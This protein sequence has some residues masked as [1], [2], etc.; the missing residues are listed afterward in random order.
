MTVIR[1]NSG[2]STE[3][4]LNRY[5]KR[6]DSWWSKEDGKQFEGVFGCVNQINTNQSHR[7]LKN[8]IAMQM[9]TNSNYHSKGMFSTN[10][11]SGAST[12]RRKKQGK[13]SLNVV[14]SATDTIV[15]KLGKNKVKPM[16]LTYGGDWFM[17]EK[18]KELGKFLQGAFYDGDFYSQAPKALLNACIFGT[19]FVKVTSPNRKI[20]YENVF[21][22]EIKVDEMDGYYGTPRN[23]YQERFIDKSTLSALYPEHADKI[24]A[25]AVVKDVVSGGTTELLRVVEA[26]HLPA[27]SESKDGK[28]AI[29]IENCDL[30]N[31]PWERESFPFAIFRWSELPVGFFGASVVD[32]LKEIQAEMNALLQSAQE[33][34]RLCSKPKVIVW[35]NSEVTTDHLNNEEG[36]IIKVKGG[37]QPPQVYA[38]NS[39][40]PE[41]FNQIE[42]LYRKAYEIVGVSMMNANGA[43]PA[44]LDS[45]PSL[46]EF[47]DI[48]TERFSIQGMKWE[49]F[50][51]NAALITIDEAKDLY[52]DDP[53]LS[54]NMISRKDGLEVVKWADV[55]ME[56]DTF[57]LQCYPTSALPT[58]PAA[59][60]QEVLEYIQSG[61]IAP[62]EGLD[63]LDFPDLD[64][65]RNRKN[66]N[67]NNI[68]KV[69]YQ[70]VHKGKYTTPEAYWN[71]GL[72][73]TLAQEFYTQCQFENVPEE[74]MQLLRNFLSDIDGLK[75]KAQQAIAEQQQQALPENAVMAPALG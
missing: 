16:P 64:S 54:V 68:N 13:L 43:K 8:V 2:Y 6:F 48:A 73:Q 11:T 46:R 29:C 57:V 61:L 47:N 25:C 12:R 70:M 65:L 55:N 34:M 20:R 53:Q 42:S 21:T 4:D 26:W 71:L 24:A 31:G 22:D 63:M 1:T 69:L 28:H 40:S 36:G 15:A 10:T 49:D 56:K 58:N 14:K 9:Y 75:A 3:N 72:A 74:R 41:I 39:V 37:S 18:A 32:E 35:D 5:D 30:Y 45:A 27:T 60:K 51:I 59:K 17:R 33:S 62:D 50:T 23:M 66:A 52:K 38:P 44:G 19:G 67:L 7:N